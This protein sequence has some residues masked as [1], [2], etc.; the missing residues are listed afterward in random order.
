MD[1]FTIDKEYKLKRNLTTGLWDT[2]QFEKLLLK[3]TDKLFK[4]YSLNLNNID[5]LFRNYFYLSNPGDFNDPFDCNVNLFEDADELNKIQS[6]TRNNYK[7]IGICAFSETINN[8]LLWAHYTK[9]YNGFVLEFR[10][11][12]IDI[13]YDRKQIKRYTLTRVIYPEK[14]VKIKKS[15]P[16]AL[17][18]LLTTKF[19]HWEYEKEWR[20]ITEI[21]G[22]ERIMNYK[23]ESVKGMY[24]GHKIPDNNK[25]IYKLLLEI[26]EMRFPKIPVYV[27]YPHPTE[28]ELNFEKVWN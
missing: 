9:N 7:D 6:V 18:Y 26:Q 11:D 21:I 4:F 12:K 16:F 10:G 2:F 24:I 20:I 14:P 27:V 22:N 23:T 25:N 19:K 13:T 17:H 15:Y 3:S 1:K 28:L 5:S 8:H